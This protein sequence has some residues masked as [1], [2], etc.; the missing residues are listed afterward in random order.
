MLKIMAL[1]GVVC[2]RKHICWDAMTYGSDSEVAGGRARA[3]ARARVCVC[4]CVCV[5]VFIYVCVQVCQEED[6]ERK[7]RGDSSH[8]SASTFYSS[9]SSHL[10]VDDNDDSVDDDDD[11]GDSV[12]SPRGQPATKT[13]CTRTDLVLS[14]FGTTRYGDEE[15]GEGGGG[16]GGGGAL[17]K[18]AAAEQTHSSSSTV[19]TSGG[20]ES[21]TASDRSQGE[22]DE[23]DGVGRSDGSVSGTS[24]K[25]RSVSQRR[26]RSTK[27]AA[28]DE[29]NN[30]GG[31]RSSAS[32]VELAQGCP[33]FSEGL[34]AAPSDLESQLGSE[35][36]MI[37]IHNMSD[38]HI[39]VF[40]A[41]A[42]EEAL[43]RGPQNDRLLRGR[44]VVGGG[45]GSKGLM[46]VIIVSI[47]YLSS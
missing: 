30:N 41:T 39:K 6:A 29:V 32:S 13:T 11:E 42:S 3:R 19:V 18:L 9:S 46:G 17:D 28:G 25:S 14:G 24:R 7:A 33:T 8:G 2:C 1:C 40:P 16:G 37:Q 10:V 20:S 45:G 12:D 15:G 23:V 26:S 22:E 43:R 5:C 4:V 44:V 21:S 36:S 35:T 27:A 38:H 47:E 34:Q 31:S